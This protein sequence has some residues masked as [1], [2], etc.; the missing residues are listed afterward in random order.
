MYGYGMAAGSSI[1]TLLLIEVVL[2]LVASIF[3]I[4]AARASMGGKL[5]VAITWIVVGL[6]T[7]SIGHMIMAYDSF[8][9]GD[10]MNTILGAPLGDIVFRIVVIFSFASS[11][12][13]F[14]R[15]WS[16]TRA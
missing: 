6:I 1:H 14:W 7:M 4:M 9:G 2:G 10:I 12:I 11:I 15:I 3:G 5:S 16:L 13:G 8:N